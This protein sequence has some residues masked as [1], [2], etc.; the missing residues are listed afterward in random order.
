MATDAQIEANRANAARS[1]G[2]KTLEGKE[3]SRGNALRHGLEARVVSALGEDGEEFE[4]HHLAL[5]HTLIPYNAYEFGL[6]R[7]LAQLS[8]RLER[9]SRMEA[10][11]LD[12]VAS[13]NASLRAHLERLGRDVSGF[14]CGRLADDLWTAELSLVAR[15]EAQL[16]NAF[17]R[18]M[19]LL[20]RSQEARRRV[21][22]DA[23][24]PNAPADADE[25]SNN[26]WNFRNEANLQ[27]EK[28][29]AVLDTR[30]HE[31]R[32]D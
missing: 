9:L 18:N 10:A 22:K 17:K 29:G 21:R 1:T 7:R 23:V 6:V 8:W 20:E 12:G 14:A 11:L 19:L 2:P 4:R 27:A 5:V 31:G 13:R 30:S 32:T 26:I 3:K 28:Q 16:D 24:R 25:R 15:Y